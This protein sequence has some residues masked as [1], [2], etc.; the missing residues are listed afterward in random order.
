MKLKLAVG[1]MLFCGV[2]AAANAAPVSLNLGSLILP[3]N[4]VANLAL[5][6]LNPVLQPVLS[7]T[8]PQVGNL[9]P[10]LHPLFLQL[11]PVFTTVGTVTGIAGIPAIPLNLPGLPN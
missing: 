3:L 9:I 8:G 11:T 5:P 10:A 1:T 4:N 6:A 7:Q 2:S